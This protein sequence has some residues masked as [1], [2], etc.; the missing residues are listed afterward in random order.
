M[1]EQKIEGVPDGWRLVAIR[2]VKNGEWFIGRAGHIEQRGGPSV[3]RCGCVTDSASVYAVIE[4]IIKYRNVTPDD[5]GKMVEICQDD[6]W[7]ERKLLAVLPESFDYR[8]IYKTAVGNDW[9]YISH[10]PRIKE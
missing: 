9:S 5:V 8:Y 7:Y 1:S 10:P 2:R 4:K 6:K 3:N